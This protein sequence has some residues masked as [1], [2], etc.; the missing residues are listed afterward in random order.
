MK[1]QLK[2]DLSIFLV[3]TIFDQKVLVAGGGMGL[4]D[5]VHRYSIAASKSEAEDN[6]REHFEE[7]EI[8]VSIVS[9]S[10]STRATVNTMIFPEQV[11]GWNEGVETNA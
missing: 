6:V 7:Q 3:T 10:V 9:G 8:N 2:A 11:I 1:Y 4:T 5:T